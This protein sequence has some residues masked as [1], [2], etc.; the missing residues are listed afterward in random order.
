MPS[1]ERPFLS[2][3]AHS[4]SQLLSDSSYLFHRFIV[5][6]S[7]PC[8]PNIPCFRVISIITSSFFMSFII[9]LTALLLVYFSIVSPLAYSPTSCFSL[10]SLSLTS[11]FPCCSSSS[12]LGYLSL[13]PCFLLIS[14]LHSPYLLRF[15]LLFYYSSVLC[16][17]FLLHFT[18]SHYIPWFSTILLI[19]LP[20]FT[21][22]HTFSF[23]YVSRAKKQNKA[24]KKPG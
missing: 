4:P 15:S 3:A 6:F 18:T 20:S 19:F 21:T 8:T 5:F 23:T 9:S 7:F 17:R 16:L 22:L 14:F 2:R 12:P 1:S 24:T 13:F 10:F 11:L